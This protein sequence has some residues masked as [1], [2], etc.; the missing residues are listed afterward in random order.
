M[1]CYVGPQYLKDS[2]NL[3]EYWFCFILMN[4][5]FLLSYCFV[6]RQEKNNLIWFLI[7]FFCIYSF[8]EVDFYGLAQFFFGV[9]DFKE[10]AYEYVRIISFGTYP[11]FRLYI[12]GC[13]LFFISKI[14]RLYTLPQNMF[15]YI[16]LIFF[17]LTFSYARASL[18]MSIYFY[19]FSKLLYANKRN[20]RQIFIGIF[21]I[22]ASFF[23]HRSMLVII[24]LTPFAFLQYNKKRLIILFGITLFMS[25]VILSY[26]TNYIENITISGGTFEN[27]EQSSVSYVVNIGEA[28][29][30]NWKF[31]LIRYLNYSSFYILT[32]YVSYIMYFKKKPKKNIFTKQECRLFSMIIVITLFS[33]LFI[34]SDMLGQQVIGYRYL[35]MTGIPLC[36][37]VTEI[38]KQRHCSWR[39]LHLLLLPAF[40]YAEGF[41]FGKIL[42]LM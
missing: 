6:F 9:E 28:E 34:G 31:T 40:L 32:L 24:V 38:V 39:M 15:I 42:S 2:A 5:C 3:G 10:P 17:L 35:Y 4:L 11:L 16:F 21:F 30:Y 27:F 14:I 29:E 23:F 20:Y 1:L 8:W 41:I 33:T 18:A 26:L 37:L 13:S 22:L 25:T 36:I 12:W 7:L 19:G